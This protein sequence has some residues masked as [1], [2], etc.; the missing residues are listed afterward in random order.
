MDFS[1]A[2]PVGKDDPW[3]ARLDVVERLAN[4]KK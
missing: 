1:N 2:G 4:E 3:K